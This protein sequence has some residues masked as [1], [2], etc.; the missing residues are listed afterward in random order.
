MKLKIILILILLITIAAT[1][2]VLLKPDLISASGLKLYRDSKDNK[3]VDDT[4][5]TSVKFEQQ[6][7]EQLHKLEVNN[8]NIKRTVS[9][10]DSAIEIKTSIPRGKPMEWVIWT[11][12]S[13]L[14]DAAYTMDDCYFESESKGCRIQF[15]CKEKGSPR[16]VL[17]LLRSS[18]YF[19]STAK[20]AI[21]IEDFGF[22]ADETTVKYLSFPE[23]LTVGLLPEKK[24]TTWTAQ[25]ADEYKKEIVLMLPMEPV[26]NAFAKQ[27]SS[28]IMVHYTEDKIKQ[29][30]S[31]AME[32]IPNFNGVSN[33]YG[34]RVLADS[35]VVSLLFDQF[36]SRKSYFLYYPQNRNISINEAV[37]STGIPFV[38][39]DV[40][41]DTTF[42]VGR[43]QDT[44]RHCAMIAQ[45]TGTVVVS[46]KALGSFIQALTNEIPV[47]K[48]N[49]IRLVYIS[50]LAKSK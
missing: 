44:L 28:V 20:M 40:Q 33:Y 6:L 13:G 19:T 7:M 14:K 41:I 37:K 26:P 2:T 31:D 36:V 24:L 48:Q 47:L 29:I 38:S 23:P 5:R 9:K 35:K 49:G 42:S 1:V 3:Q 16:F 15:S 25:I 12:T 10:Q 8:Q 17:I 32:K 45:K 18:A 46:S 43:I 50:E 4:V 21:F 11:I 30:V 27:S 34:S 39:I 22:Q